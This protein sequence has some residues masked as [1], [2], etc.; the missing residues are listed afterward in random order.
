MSNQ[1]LTR[2]SD[3]QPM[4]SRQLPGQPPPEPVTIDV[5][6]P[7]LKR[8][9]AGV[10][11]YWQMIRRHKLAVLVVACIGALGGF[12]ST[13]SNPRIYQARTTLEI[14]GLNQEFLNMKNMSPTVESGSTDVDADIQTQVKL[15]QSRSLL[16]RVSEK[17]GS[18][19]PPDGL[20][21]SDR[22]GV[23]RKALGI[24][25]PSADQL[26]KL[27]QGKQLPLP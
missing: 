20:R 1:E 12:A 18:M 26:W 3:L 16:R 6:G 25:P 2:Y 21:P 24:N 14:Q 15:L 13:L 7:G 11:E 10:L 17:L 23:W 27:V 22:L 4:A 5:P 9:Y 19:P 8:D